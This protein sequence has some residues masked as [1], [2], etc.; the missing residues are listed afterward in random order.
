MMRFATAITFVALL[1]LPG[2]TENPER[3]LKSELKGKTVLIRGFYQDDKL[4]YNSQGEVMGT[5]QPGSWTVAK[6]QVKSI[7]VRPNEFQIRGPRLISFCNQSKGEFSTLKPSRKQTIRVTV[8]ASL[9]SLNQQQL[10]DLIEKVLVTDPSPDISVFPRYWREF[11][12]GHVV[13]VQDKNGKIAFKRQD[14]AAAEAKGDEQPIY[15]NFAGDPVFRVSKTLEHPKILSQIDPEYSE[16]ARTQKFSGTTVVS[17]EVDKSGTV[18]D[19]QILQPIGYGLDD[20]AVRAV[21]QWRFAPARRNGEPVA[22][23]TSAEVS[24]RLY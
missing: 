18:R 5:P 10:G 14:D 16:S 8:H 9:S 23:L 19:V 7:T 1:A 17:L 22:V 11:L 3:Q 13:R 24:F 12:S 2:W 15:T 6:M 21:E 4:E 20:Q